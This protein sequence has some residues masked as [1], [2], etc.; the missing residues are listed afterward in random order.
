M[1]K[2]VFGL[3][4]LAAA[5]I[6][7]RSAPAGAQTW[8][9][10]WDKVIAAANA[11]GTLVL[12]SQPNIEMRKYVQEE[13][14][15]AYPKIALSI[16]TTPGA[17]FLARVRTERSVDKYLWDV[18]VSSVATAFTFYHEGVLDPLAP[19]F[20]LPDVKDPATWG[21]WDNVFMDE[22]GK[23]VFGMSA[24]L[25]S[26]YYNTAQVAADKIAQL[27]LTTLLDPAYKGKILWHDPLVSGSG[28]TFA[29]VL[30][31]RLGDDGLRRLILD[32]KVV[33]MAQQDQVVEA[34]ARGVGW[35]SIGPFVRAHLEP[36]LAAGVKM[37]V[38]AFGNDP[39]MNE[40]G[41]GGAGLYVYNKRPHPNAT[42][43]FVNWI[44]SK[45]IQLGLAK[46]TLQDSRRQDLPS[47]S[48][49]ERQPIK[50]AH[51]LE[52]QREEHAQ[53]LVDAIKF[54]GEVRKKPAP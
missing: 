23:Y 45:D 50:G 20:I 8:Q 47:V 7:A 24:A 34:M 10:E 1:G 36:Y 12:D 18:S 11:E 14:A 43:V 51:Y 31:T 42:R 54:I 17:Q 49:P 9:A 16:S 5:L 22:A 25:K 15:K 40:M 19:E 32:Q 44:L 3:A 38:R 2:R 27:G 46:A 48:E 29:Y 52:T 6:L 41:T 39:A 13:W 4:I 21:G 26:P 35:I 28:Q 33:F 30:R 37:D 53:D